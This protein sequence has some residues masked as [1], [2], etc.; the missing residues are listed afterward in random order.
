MPRASRRSARAVRKLFGPGV[1]KAARERAE[2]EVGELDA[3][4]PAVLFGRRA[5]G[6]ALDVEHVQRH[7]VGARIGL[8]AER[9]EVARDG[10][11]PVKSARLVGLLDGAARHAG[12][13]EPHEDAR[14]GALAL[15]GAGAHGDRGVA[16]V[17]VAFPRV[18]GGLDGAAGLGT[19]LRREH[20]PGGFDLG[21]LLGKQRRAALALDAARAFARA[22]GTAKRGVE[23]VVGDENGAYGEHGRAP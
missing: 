13:V 14:A 19:E 5:D 1:A 4:A 15:A 2:H 8:H 16:V 6:D 22:E 3:A 21:A 23:Q 7:A 20:V 9:E 12:L 10:L 18:A 17:L 11:G